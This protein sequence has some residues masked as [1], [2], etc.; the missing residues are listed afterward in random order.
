M[1]AVFGLF[2]GFYYWFD[3]L[4]GSKFSEE[5]GKIHFWLTFVGVN[6]TFFP[7][8]FLGL[9]GM[10]RRIPDYPDVYFGWNYISSI[11]SLISVIGVIVFFY[12]VTVSLYDSNLYIQKKNSFYIISSKKPL[13]QIPASIKPKIAFILPILNF[14][15]FFLPK[16]IFLFP[17]YNFWNILPNNDLMY[18][19]LDR[20]LLSIFLSNFSNTWIIDKFFNKFFGSTTKN[21]S[22]LFAPIR[23]L[24]N[25]NNINN[26]L[27][28]CF[29]FLFK[30]WL[31]L[32]VYTIYLL[33]LKQVKLI[34]KIQLLNII[35]FKFLGIKDNSGNFLFLLLRRVNI[36][37]K[38]SLFL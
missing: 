20:Y 31:S 13:L 14:F 5:Y 11:G 6:L 34:F 22:K 23:S 2:A 26:S 9:A 21:N 1:G 12:T 15:G 35:F 29:I 10:P 37:Q 28:S 8:H 36:L 27:I 7:Q 4:I 25:F 17:K 3:I 19:Y 24:Y 18:I 33:S 32:F 30:G 38:I 16:K